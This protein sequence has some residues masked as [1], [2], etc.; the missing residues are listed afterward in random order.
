MPFRLTRVEVA[1]F[2]DGQ[3]VDR[4]LQTFATN[5]NALKSSLLTFSCP[6]EKDTP[7][8]YQQYLAD[9]LETHIARFLR[10]GR[11]IAL[12]SP[13]YSE[14][15]G[16]KADV[17]VAAPSG[18]GLF[19]E[20]EFR[21]NVEKDLAKFQ[22]G[23]HSG[24]LAIGILILALRRNSINAGYTTMPEFAKFVRVIPQFRPQHP[25]LLVGIDG[26]HAPEPRTA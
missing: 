13:R 7:G 4:A 23:H 3:A 5:T 24:R 16:E 6:A 26:E 10:Q 15:L 21:P 11:G 19:V 22:I 18:A 9:H 1:A 14:L 25:L 17:A 20:I 8:G 12:A 2:P